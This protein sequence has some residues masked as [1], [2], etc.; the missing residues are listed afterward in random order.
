VH[1]NLQHG[2]PGQ[3]DVVVDGEVVASR[4]TG[5]L[6]LLLGSGWPRAAD[7]IAAIGRKQAAAKV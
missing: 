5:F 4:K 6:Q 3:F 2:D 1:V 7:V